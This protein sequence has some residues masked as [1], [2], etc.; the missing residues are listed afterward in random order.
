MICFNT[1]PRSFLQ[2]Q[3]INLKFMLSFLVMILFLPFF[4]FTSL[5]I[6]SLKY[7]FVHLHVLTEG[8]GVISFPSGC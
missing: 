3:E 6:F 4:S 1:S 5:E 7:G 2:F 8:H